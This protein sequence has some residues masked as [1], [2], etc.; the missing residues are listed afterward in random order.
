[1]KTKKKTTEAYFSCV[2]AAVER[3]CRLEV[4]LH[5]LFEWPWNVVSTKEVFEI[6]GFGLVDGSP[7]VH[8]LNDGAHIT[9]HDSVHQSCITCTLPQ[10]ARSS[11]AVCQHGVRSLQ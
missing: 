5:A 2:D 3:P 7:S 10:Y 6:A 9:E 1:M 4:I 8:A 11:T